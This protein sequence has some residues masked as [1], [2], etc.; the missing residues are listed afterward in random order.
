[1]NGQP[2]F[3][4][5]LPA[6]LL[7]AAVTVAPG[8]ACAADTEL[9]AS[10]DRLTAAIERMNQQ[11]LASATSG[12]DDLLRRLSLA[13]AYLDYRSRRIEALER[14]MSEN[15]NLQ[16]RLD[17]YMRQIDRR[18][19]ALEESLRDNP[20]TP[21]EEADQARKEL[22]NQRKMVVDRIARIDGKMIQLENE[23]T[24]LKH[25]LVPIEQFIQNNLEF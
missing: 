19:D 21:R 9:A 24:D 14:E 15:R 5:L 20:Q 12:Q 23:I 10:I 1:M 7:L 25:Q 8:A 4:R 17:D 3:S 11:Q 18:E 22:D 2:I 16:D 13:V 6:V